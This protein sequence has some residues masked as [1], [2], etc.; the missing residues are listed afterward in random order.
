MLELPVL[1]R[2]AQAA[3]QAEAIN[4]RPLA[5][6]VVGRVGFEGF[7]STI[8]NTMELKSRLFLLDQTA[9]EEQVLTLP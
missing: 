1:V 5:S 3:E 7:S 9:S 2:M 6:L 8:W 4:T